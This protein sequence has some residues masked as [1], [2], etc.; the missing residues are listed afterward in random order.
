MEAYKGFA[1]VYDNFMDEIDYPAWVQYIQ[2]AWKRLGNVPKTVIDLGC[3]TGNVTIPL[4][5]AGYQVFG[6]DISEDMLAEAQRKAFLDELSIPFY[7]QD[8]VQLGLSIQVDCVLSLC[9][10]LNYLTEEGE[11]SAAF[12]AIKRHLNPNGLFLFDMN[13]EYKFKNVLGDKTYAATTED[14]AYFWEN[15][16]DEEEQMNEYYVSF[17]L[18]QENKDTYERVEEYHYE[19]AYS[20]ETV[21]ACLEENGFELLNVYDGYCFERAKEDS[22]RYFFVAQLKEKM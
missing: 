19:K 2:E 18:R 13:T 9:D 8:M 1:S 6:V 17:F 16:Y 20:L 14:S 4:A 7:C 3:G 15:S 10:S 21:K 11:L 5:K 12:C 22:Q